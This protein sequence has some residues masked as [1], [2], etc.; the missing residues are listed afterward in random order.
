MSSEGFPESVRSDVNLKRYHYAVWYQERLEKQVQEFSETLK[1]DEELLI[2]VPLR[3]GTTIVA[4]WFGY[5]NP[6]MLIVVGVDQRDGNEVEL[7][8]PHTDAQVL[9]KKVKVGGEAPRRK[10]IGFQA[11]TKPGDDKSR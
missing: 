4:T 8:I 10:Q 1:G 9:L 6:N 2:T 3:N 7:L 5:Y 11:R